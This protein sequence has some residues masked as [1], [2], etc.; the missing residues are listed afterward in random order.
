MQANHFIHHIENT[1]NWY[2]RQTGKFATVCTPFDTEL[3]GHWWF[4]GPQFIKAVLKGFHSSPYVKPATA[5]EQL[6]KLKPREVI[7]IPEGSWGENNNHDV[8]SNKNTKWTWETI[9]NNENR[10]NKMFDMFPLNNM[11]PVIRRILTQALR[12]M[13]LLQSSDWPFL[14]H[15]LS[16]KDYAEQR[17]SFHHSD[18]N[19]LCDLAENYENNQKLTY[20]EELFL[21]EVEKRNSCFAELK[22]EW[23][24]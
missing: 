10:L 19:K 5:S 9:Y 22:L 7:S 13:M 23:W 15:T 6:F 3:F 2:N 8:W 4:E 21:E 12:E 18:F 20:Q 17:F 16:A 11:N 24:V 14:I 1:S